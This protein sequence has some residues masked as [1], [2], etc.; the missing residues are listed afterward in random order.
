MQLKSGMGTPPG[1]G[2][3]VLNPEVRL[4]KHYFFHELII[5][6]TTDA[7]SRGLLKGFNTAATDAEC[8]VLS[9]KPTDGPTYNTWQEAFNPTCCCQEICSRQVWPGIAQHINFENWTE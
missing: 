8:E 4:K 2:H 9:A 7:D 6:D 5:A 3:Q 1:K